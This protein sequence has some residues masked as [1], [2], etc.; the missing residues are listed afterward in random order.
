MLAEH[1][2]RARFCGNFFETFCD[3]LIAA[4]RQLDL[5]TWFE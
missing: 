3:W 2:S 4:A 1:A 5:T